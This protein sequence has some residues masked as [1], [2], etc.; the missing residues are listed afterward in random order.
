MVK[1]ICGESDSSDTCV[2]TQSIHPRV[3]VLIVDVE[4]TTPDA[5]ASPCW[6]VMVPMAVE[7][8]WLFVTSPSLAVM[9]LYI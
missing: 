7:H 6:G 9:R 2:C 4:H 5:D 8:P 1:S 3:R